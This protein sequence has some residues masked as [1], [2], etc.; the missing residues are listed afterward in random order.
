MRMAAYACGAKGLMNAAIF[1]LLAGRVTRR[2]NLVLRSSCR[3][4]GRGD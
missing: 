1:E 2:E 3:A 4:D